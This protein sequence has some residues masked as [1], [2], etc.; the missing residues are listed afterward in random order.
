M[1]LTARTAT[2]AGV[3]LLAATLAAGCGGGGGGLERVAGPPPPPISGRAIADFELYVQASEESRILFADIYGLDLEPLTPHRLTSGKRISTMDA[4]AEHIVVAA[5][6][7][8]IDRLGYLLDGGEIGPIPGLGRPYAFSP[9]FETDGSILYSDYT[10]REPGDAGINRFFD[11]DP[12]TGKRKLLIKTPSDDVY[13][14]VTG[15]MG[16]R[17]V[18][19]QPGRPNVIVIEDADGGKRS[20]RVPE[21]TGGLIWGARWIALGFSVEDQKFGV[22]PT[23]LVL[24]DPESGERKRV[25]GWEPLTWTPDGTRLLVRKTADP[26]TSELALLDPNNPD[27]L[28]PVGTLPN[29]T[30][31]GAAWVDRSP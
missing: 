9:T 3:T 26:T 5:A 2:A 7:G 21:D 6:D 13:G 8:D 20:I 25:D 29:F 24:L 19:G 1:W 11:W 14:P 23:D 22:L 17:A 30:I 27:D 10:E 16:Q 31:Y 4:N 15:P 18:L 28:E 12:Q